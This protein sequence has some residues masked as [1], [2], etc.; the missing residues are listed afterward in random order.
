MCCKC[1]RCRAA[2]DD[3][4]VG[5]VLLRTLRDDLKSSM[6][7]V[8]RSMDKL[9]LEDDGLARSLPFEL[10]ENADARVICCPSFKGA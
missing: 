6:L 7:L 2:A 8:S 3:S 10:D 1:G 9:D 5:F 4:G